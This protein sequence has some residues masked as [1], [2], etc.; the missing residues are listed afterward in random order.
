[1]AHTSQGAVWLSDGR[2]TT[3]SE[4]AGS[5]AQKD[6]PTENGQ[7]A[8]EPRFVQTMHLGDG[9]SALSTDGTFQSTFDREDVLASS[10]LI[11]VQDAYIRN[12]ERD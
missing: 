10:R 11:Y 12:I 2:R 7:V 5:D 6:W 8:E 9:S 1:M 4:I 3:D